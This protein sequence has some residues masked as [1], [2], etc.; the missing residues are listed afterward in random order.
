MEYSSICETGARIYTIVY[1]LAWEGLFLDPETF[2]ICNNVVFCFLSLPSI[3]ALKHF[4]SS[5]T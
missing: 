5:G 1:F 2:L 4:F 3:F